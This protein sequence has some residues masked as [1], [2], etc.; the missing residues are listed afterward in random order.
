MADAYT[1]SYADVIFVTVLKFISRIDEGIFQ[2][3]LSL[4]PAFPKV[5]EAS[6]KWLAKED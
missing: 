4:D 3:Y 6:K 2:R 5:Y 1:V